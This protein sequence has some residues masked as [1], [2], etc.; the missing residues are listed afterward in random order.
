M[1]LSL[2]NSVTVLLLLT[3]KER[4][5]RLVNFETLYQ[6]DEETWPDQQFVISWLCEFWLTTK[7]QWQGYCK[8]ISKKLICVNYHIYI[9][10]FLEN[11]SSGD[12]Q[13][14]FHK[15]CFQNFSSQRTICQ[16]FF[17]EPMVFCFLFVCTLFGE[18]W[19]AEANFLKSAFNLSRHLWC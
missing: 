18:N 11:L 3:Y 13:S 17:L 12:H 15:Q 4:P 2:T 7:T 19:E 10:K 5:K 8:K 14:C 1:T 9:I 16:N 6:S